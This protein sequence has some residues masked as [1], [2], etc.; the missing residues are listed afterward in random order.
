MI[1]DYNLKQFHLGFNTVDS[2]LKEEDLLKIQVE[3]C[4]KLK[5]LLKNENQT[6]KK[7]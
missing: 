1:K 6:K 7:N 3:V 4:C 2:K 5:K